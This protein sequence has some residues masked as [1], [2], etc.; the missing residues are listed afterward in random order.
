LPGCLKC[1]APGIALPVASDLKRGLDLCPLARLPTYQQKWLE[2]LPRVESATTTINNLKAVARLAG[3]DKNLTTHT[4]RHSFADRGRRLGIATADMRDMLNHHSISQ[5]EGYYGELERS[6][7]S[8][9]AVSI[10]VK[11]VEPE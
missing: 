9:K 5:T 6:E 11:R 8:V 3:I 7:L 4:A 10:Y 2:L 1:P